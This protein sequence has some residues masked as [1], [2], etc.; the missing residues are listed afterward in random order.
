MR[1]IGVAPDQVALAW[2]STRGVVPIS[3]RAR[4]SNFAK[5]SVR[6]SCNSLLSML[7]DWMQRA[8]FRSDFPMI[9]WL[10]LDKETA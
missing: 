4:L 7:L 10:M 5:T 2:L 6:P 3:G 1:E 9:F 8:R